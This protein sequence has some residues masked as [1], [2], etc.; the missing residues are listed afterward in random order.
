MIRWV[1]VILF[2]LILIDAL[3]PWL[4]RFGIGKLPGDLEFFL[5]GRLWRIPLTSTLILSVF[6]ALIAKWL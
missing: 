3:S 6:C 2:V 4:K 1:L 5:F